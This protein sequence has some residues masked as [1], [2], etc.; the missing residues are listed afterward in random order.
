MFYCEAKPKCR[1]KVCAN[2]HRFIIRPAY[3]SHRNTHKRPHTHKLTHTHTLNSGR[4]SDVRKIKKI[5][6][7][8]NCIVVHDKVSC[9]NL[10]I[11]FATGM[12]DKGVKGTQ[13]QVT[14]TGALGH[15]Y[16]SFYAPVKSA[17]QLERD[18][19]KI[20]QMTFQTGPGVGLL[21]LNIAFPCGSDPSDIALPE[22]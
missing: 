2:A 13:N 16:L 19:S 9:K 1:A 17:K 4:R 18:A 6:D 8:F 5:K 10:H 20:V 12:N 22:K 14:V 15:M 3:I 11:T 21:A 7:G